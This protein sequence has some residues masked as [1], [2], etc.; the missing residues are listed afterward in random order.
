LNLIYRATRNGFLA[1]D[2]HRECDNQGETFI[3]I[4]SINDYDEERI[5]GAYTDIPWTS[6]KGYKFGKGNSFLITMS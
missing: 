3:I 5:C 6:V 2:F 1:E 4:K